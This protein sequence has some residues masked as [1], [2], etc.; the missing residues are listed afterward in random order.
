MGIRAPEVELRRPGA[1]QHCL[2]PRAHWQCLPPRAHWQ[3]LPPGAHQHCLPPCA[4]QHYLPVHISPIS[5]PQSCCGH[6]AGLYCPEGCGL[7][8]HW[9]W[10]SA[11]SLCAL[12]RSLDVVKQ[13]ILFTPNCEPSGFTNFFLSL[14]RVECSLQKQNVC[15]PMVRAQGGPRSWLPHP[16][17]SGMPSAIL[18]PRAG[19]ATI[20]CSVGCQQRGD[21]G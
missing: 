17:C 6:S 8:Q 13:R 20:M 2:P 1:H 12:E 14:C 9:L 10:S 16:L 4:H 11:R 18:G 5:V 3:C 21:T 7:R 15:F 19:T